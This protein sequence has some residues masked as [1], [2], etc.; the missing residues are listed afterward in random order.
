[1]EENKGKLVDDW[2]L[3]L[4][5]EAKQLTDEE[6]RQRSLVRIQE[7]YRSYNGEDRVVPSTDILE[8]MKNRPP[9]HKIMTGI[10]G[11]DDIL[12]GIVLK[13]LVVLAAPTKAGKT[14]MC[15]ELTIQMRDQN[16]L[17]LS[18]EEPVEELLQ[19]FIDR[20]V[21][22]PLFFSP[23]RMNRVDKQLTWLEWIEKK[24]I[25]A[26]AKYDTQVIFIDH[27][28]FIVPF[29]SER[30]DLM[31]GHTMRQLKQ[32]AKAWN[33]VIVL[34]AH[35]K[36]TRLIQQP[37]LED[38][39]DSSFIAQE[40]DTVIMLWRKTERIEGQV[41]IGNEVNVSVQANRRTGK[42]G[43]VSLM[44][45]EGRFL[46]VDK[47]HVEPR[48]TKAQKKADEEFDDFHVGQR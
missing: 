40:A 31:I 48:K 33:V 15:M 41:V 19:K 45:S 23:E 8:A 10:K 24:I 25:E 39:R 14:T 32:L 12:D 6:Q 27:L 17:W 2:I 5:G 38:L 28:H 37:D 29:S 13:Q 46:P 26:K 36:K 43:N 21:T 47:I 4:E 18:F 1:M 30:Q 9:I 11:L 34:I 22:P 42:T 16:P 7:M 3:T 35:L 44:F 20:G